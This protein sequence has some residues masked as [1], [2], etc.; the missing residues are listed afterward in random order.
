MVLLW[1]KTGDP[2]AFAHIQSAWGRALAIPVKSFGVV[3]IKPY[4]LASDWNLR[5]LNFIAFFAAAAT[6]A[7]LIRRGQWGL[8]I[9]TGLSVLAPAMTGPL[10]SMARYTFALFPL[11]MAYA[12][13]AER[14]SRE[15]A[16]LAVMAMILATL[17]IAFERN[18]AFA[19]A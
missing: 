10:T 3:L 2:L 4:F 1:T 9:F 8:A 5:P 12:L 14:G 16:T 13:W 18:L 17:V 15:R 11:A 6:A 7:W 19:G